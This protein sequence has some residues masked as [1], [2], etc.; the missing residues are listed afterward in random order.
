MWKN[1]VNF[2]SANGLPLPR[3]VCVMGGFR[4]GTNYLRFLLEENYHV[5]VVYDDYGWKHAGVPIRFRRRIGAQFRSPII[6]IAKDPFAYLVSLH[7]Y[8]L[9]RGSNI[10]AETEWDA[11]LRSPFVIY[12][13]FKARYPLYHFRTPV[14]Y[15]NFINWNLAFLPEAT[16]RSGMLSYEQVLADPEAEVEAVAR[17]L[18]LRRRQGDFK[19][20]DGYL[21]RLSD[22]SGRGDDP[23][24][25]ANRQ[26]DSSSVH[27]K[28][29][30][31]VYSE[32]QRAF[33]CSQLDIRLL[34]RLGYGGPEYRDMLGERPRQV[35]V[36]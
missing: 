19:L 5:H 6:G 29:Y 3:Y 31:E 30:L 18:G 27:E 9:K 1:L 21:K 8:Y 13:R 7:A 17:P 26:F 11:F 35:A 28:R 16:I 15:W 33:V 36:G 12:D 20:P 14:Q 2:G 23:K 24:I 32:A 22:Q 4:S 34:D 25:E 10:D